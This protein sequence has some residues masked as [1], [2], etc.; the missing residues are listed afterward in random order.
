[1]AMSMCLSILLWDYAAYS[2]VPV[3]R[4]PIKRGWAH[5]CPSGGGLNVGLFVSLA[6]E[7]FWL[8]WDMISKGSVH[9]WVRERISCYMTD[10]WFLLH[11]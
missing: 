7:A 11:D 3:V 5:I 6:E 9:N 2:L 8:D 4:Y 1:M 10:V